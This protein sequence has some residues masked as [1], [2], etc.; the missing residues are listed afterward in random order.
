MSRE[1]QGVLIG[2]SVR[3]VSWWLGD[4]KSLLEWFKL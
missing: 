2:K 1:T 3:T 4:D